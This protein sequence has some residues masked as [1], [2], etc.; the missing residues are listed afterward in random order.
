MAD[1]IVSTNT[2]AALSV[3]SDPTPVA[4]PAGSRARKPKNDTGDEAIVRCMRAWNYTYRKVA[5]DLDEDSSS[6]PAE[7]AANQ[8]YLRAAPPLR[9]YDNICDF[10]ACI[11]FASMTDIIIHRE[12]AH[13]LANA[14]LALSAVLRK[15]ETSN[16]SGDLLVP[17][18]PG[19][20]RSPQTG[21]TPK[22][23]N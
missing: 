8:A 17:A 13:Y 7:K 22:A 14:K 18:G 19:S 16:S 4:A 1:L 11:N 21:D 3:T 9:G 6:Y 12:A 2:A 23:A 15:P 20:P 5:A 10:I